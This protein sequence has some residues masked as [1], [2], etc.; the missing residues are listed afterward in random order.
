MSD[1]L[2]LKV[3]RARDVPGEW[4][5]HCLDFD[6]VTQGNSRAHALRMVREAV[7]I[8][9]REDLAAGRN[10]HARRAPPEFW[11]T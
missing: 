2:W 9:V 4:V 6:V 10:P 5:A 7:E 8:V 11:T 1:R 3:S